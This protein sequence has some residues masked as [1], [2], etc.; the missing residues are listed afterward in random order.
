M[1]MQ[2]RSF[3]Y[4]PRIETDRKCVRMTIAGNVYLLSPKEALAVA[5]DIANALEALRGSDG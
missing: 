5:T 1:K 4:R 2:A 3:R